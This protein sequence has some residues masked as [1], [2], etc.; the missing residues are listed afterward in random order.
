MSP[1]WRYLDSKGAYGTSRLKGCLTNGHP[2][3]LSELTITI[4][5]NIYGLSVGWIKRITRVFL[6]SA[7]EFV[8]VGL[9]K[10][11]VPCGNI[12]IGCKW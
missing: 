1:K 8:A 5:M 4:M 10:V 9:N 7:I 6:I 12:S 3:K 2:E 11:V